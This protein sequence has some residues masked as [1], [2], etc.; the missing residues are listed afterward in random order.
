LL[1]AYLKRRKTEKLQQSWEE[2]E[3]WLQELEDRE[4]GV[5]SSEPLLPN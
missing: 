1:A 3:R 4:R 5:G 2:E